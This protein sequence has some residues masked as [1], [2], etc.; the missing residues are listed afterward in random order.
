MP[1]NVT[2]LTPPIV[3]VNVPLFVRLPLIEKVFPPVRV[4]EAPELMTRFLQKEAAVMDGWFGTPVEIETSVVAV[5]TV[6]LHQ[7]DA[8][9]QLD[10]VPI[11]PP[12]KAET[13][14]C[15]VTDM[16]VQPPLVADLLN[17]VVCA[18]APGV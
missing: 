15:T 13:V 14:I 18:K 7:L 11:H 10:V 3:D 16:P 1:P 5:G 4:T 6:L 9:F 17:Q 2:W 12:D 8:V